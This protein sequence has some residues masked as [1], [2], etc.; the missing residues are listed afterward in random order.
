MKNSGENKKKKINSL[1]LNVKIFL[2]KSGIDFFQLLFSIF[3][4]KIIF[5]T[6]NFPLFDYEFI[7]NAA[8]HDSFMKN[9]VDSNQNIDLF[10]KNKEEK[11]KF[12]EIY[13]DTVRVFVIACGPKDHIPKF[14][15][16]NITTARCHIM[17]GYQCHEVPYMLDFLINW[18]DNLTEE[19]VVFSHGHTY[20]WHT[21][22]IVTSLQRE[23]NT[24]YFKENGFGGFRLHLW[25]RCC[26]DPRYQDIYPRMFQDTSI[27]RVWNRYSTYPCCSTFFVKTETI[28]KRPKQDYINIYRNLQNWVAVNPN[29][30]F[31]C[32]RVFE[33]TWHIIFTG[34]PEVPQPS[35]VKWMV[36]KP[37][38]CKFNYSD[39][40]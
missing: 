28:R 40:N 13:P 7:A 14:V 35:Y 3:L 4:F 16:A 26:D 6:T 15:D 31:H 9:N 11:Q 24:D 12:P 27:P 20:S 32:G 37:G 33:Y 1:L 30:S 23:R 25:K 17:P 8:P 10:S 18:Y 29:I 19:T 22:N 2:T 34:K 39:V 21:P 36:N 38:P 5:S